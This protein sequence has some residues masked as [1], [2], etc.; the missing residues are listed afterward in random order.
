MTAALVERMAP[1]DRW[2]LFQR[3]VPPAPQRPQGGGH[4]R[5]G[6]REVL[7]AIIFVATSGCTWNQ[8]PP[9]FGLS[10][11]TAFRRFTEWSE[12]RVWAKLHRLVLDELGARGDL[13]WS[14]C[15]IDSVSVRALKGLLTGPNP[16]DRGKK[17]SKIHLLVDR[18]GLPL[19]IGISAANLHDSQALIPLVRGIPPIRS[20]R[21]RRRRRP[22]K[23]HADKGYDYRHLRRWLSS[24]GIQ[25]RIA[26]KGCESSRRLGRH[27]WVVERTMSWLSGCR[28]L[29][30][31]YE[32][33]PEHFLA[34]TA[35]A[36]TLICHRRLTN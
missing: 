1:E 31:R 5:R 3:V 11:V 22:G 25:H 15:A 8:L 19:S 9:G 26:R 14:R 7:A 4:R 18:N 10:G 13:D 29:H 21:G 16:T 20:R 17:G 27:R 12:A 28:R 6:D 33:K 36:A 23:L 32:R 30:R 35:I 34:F 24:R 2:A